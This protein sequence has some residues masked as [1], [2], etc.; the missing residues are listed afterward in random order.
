LLVKVV[1][2][3]FSKGTPQ[4]VTLAY[5]G[6]W[7][8][9][10]VMKGVLADFQ[11]QNP[12]ITVVYTKENVKDYRDRVLTRMQNGNGSDV[13]LFH[14]TWL[15]EMSSVLTPL[16]TDVIGADTFQKTYYPVVVS[17]LTK[18]GAIYGM[19]IGIDT[20]SLFINSEIFQNAGATA[21]TNWEDFGKVARSLTV[22]DEQGKI[23]TAGAAIGTFDNI[24][25]APDLIAL[26]FVQ[27]GVNLL[28]LSATS[29][30]VSDALDFYTSFAK[31]QGKVWDDTLDPSQLAFAKGNLA[32]YFGYSWDIFT[33]KAL[34]P[35][36]S[37]QVV[38]VPHLPGRDTTI[39]SYWANGVSIKSKHQKEALL[40]LK[41]LSQKDVSQKIFSEESKVRL[42]GEPYA[43]IDLSDSLKSNK[44]VY[45]FV[46]Q[47][48]NAASS[49]F[50]S[51]TYDNGL[52]DHM[53]GYLGNAVR[54]IL[55]NTSTDTAVEQLY[56]G[57]AQVE[58]Q[59][60][61]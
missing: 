6:L 37:F 51:N 19:P 25:H 55:G 35:N 52:N 23:K 60:G 29:K 24:T 38:P 42:F 33:I 54:S 28:N 4:T 50:A 57:V 9:E 21:P 17:D 48:N 61:Q 44:L 27:N 49:Y 11:K 34:N 39:A 18:N 12:T 2:P 8:D 7:D 30:S 31:D 20:L 46:L 47:A 10:N 5:W 1:L 3:K 16:P 58:A 14:N 15:P 26:L 22:E 56:K 43:Q 59:Y 45:P 13:F 32:M 36:L 40:L 41:Y 53:N